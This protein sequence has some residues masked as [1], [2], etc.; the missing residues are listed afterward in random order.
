MR[1]RGKKTAVGA[2]V[3]GLIVLAVAGVVYQGEIV[4][5]WN[6]HQAKKKVL[7]LMR[8]IEAGEAGVD[9]PI[10]LEE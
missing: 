8:K 7:E 4:D 3:I 5:H 2:L 9:S 1:A 6:R 10:L